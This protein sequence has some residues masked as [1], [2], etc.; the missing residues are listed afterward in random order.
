VRSKIAAGF[1]DG[2]ISIMDGRF[3]YRP[4]WLP[5]VLAVHWVGRK[6]LIIST[7]VP[8]LI[9]SGISNNAYLTTNFSKYSGTI[10]TVRTY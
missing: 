5:L 2:V 7:I 4:L 6:V 3:I 8:Y 10:S 1:Q 9:L